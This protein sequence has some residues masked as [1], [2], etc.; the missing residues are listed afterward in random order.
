MPPYPSPPADVAADASRLAFW[1]SQVDE[2]RKIFA[3]DVLWE[4]TG[5]GRREVLSCSYNRWGD[6][7]YCRNV[8]RADGTVES[9]DIPPN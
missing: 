6:R 1:R 5:C 3:A 2:K 8:L 9:V 4:A 7:G